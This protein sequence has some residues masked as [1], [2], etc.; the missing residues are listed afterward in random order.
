[1]SRKV[2]FS[3]GRWTE[4]YF[5][6]QLDVFTRDG[7]KCQYC[8]TQEKLHSHHIIGWDE[9]ISLRY[10]LTNGLTLCSSCHT[11]HHS[12][13]RVPWNK[14]KK[15]DEA[16]RKKLSDAHLGQKAWNKGKKHSPESIAKMVASKTGK[17][18]K[19][20]SEEHKQKIGLA[21][22][23]HLMVFSE[24][25]RGKTWFTCPDTGK[26]TWKDKEI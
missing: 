24:S 6:W 20:F 3:H 18:L 14:G 2:D 21:N 15:L 22:R 9:D 11:R 7:F 4:R 26:R 5:V 23:K 25:R 16:G 1:M 12:L 17:K 8:G 19:P 13:G 10:E